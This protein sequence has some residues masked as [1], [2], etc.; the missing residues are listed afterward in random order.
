MSETLS[1]PTT[2]ELDELV[3]DVETREVHAYLAVTVTDDDEPAEEA[4]GF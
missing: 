4:F 3:R 1:I 2:T